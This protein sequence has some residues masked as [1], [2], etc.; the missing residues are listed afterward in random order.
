MWMQDSSKDVEEISVSIWYK[1]Y[2]FLV[3]VKYHYTRDSFFDKKQV[4]IVFAQSSLSLCIE[5]NVLEKSTC[6]SVISR[7]FALMPSTI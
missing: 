5:A 3:F 2:S 1:N 6:S 4:Q 7:F